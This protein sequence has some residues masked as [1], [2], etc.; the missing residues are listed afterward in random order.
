MIDRWFCPVCSKET[1]VYYSTE[2]TINCLECFTVLMK[3]EPKPAP[4]GI[5]VSDGIKVNGR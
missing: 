2:E 3:E 4:L 1:E 5:S